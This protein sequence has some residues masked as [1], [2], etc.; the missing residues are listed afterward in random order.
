MFLL[1]DHWIDIIQSSYTF[2]KYRLLEVIGKI[3]DLIFRD[4]LDFE[5]LLPAITAITDYDKIDCL[6]RTIIRKG[7]EACEKFVYCLNDEQILKS[8]ELKGY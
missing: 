1:T 5:E 3:E 4:V 7:D 2:L 6:L 8:H